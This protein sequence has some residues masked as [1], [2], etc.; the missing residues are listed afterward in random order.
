[1]IT[2]LKKQMAT[3]AEN[4]F[5][6]LNGWKMYSTLIEK[7]IAETKVYSPKLIGREY[8]SKAQRLGNNLAALESEILKDPTGRIFIT[9]F[10][11]Q[12]ESFSK[13]L[14]YKIDRAAGDDIR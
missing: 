14:Q 7:I 11:Y 2:S 10:A 3:A 5:L 8:L 1:M 13:D 9:R 12:A 6:K 4:N